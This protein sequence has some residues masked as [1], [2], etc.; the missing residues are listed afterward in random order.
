M[1][2][3]L[4]ATF[5][6]RRLH[7][8]RV[9]QDRKYFLSVLRN[10][11]QKVFGIV[12]FFVPNPYHPQEHFEG[13]SDAQQS[14]AE[15][16][17]EQRQHAIECMRRKQEA[18]RGEEPAQT[19]PPPPP[20]PPPQPQP[21][22]PPP[23][24]GTPRCLDD[25]PAGVAQ[26]RALHPGE[27]ADAPP[28]PPPPPPPP[29]VDPPPEPPLV[30]CEDQYRDVLL[31]LK[32]MSTELAECDEDDYFEEGEGGGGG[33]GGGA[34]PFVSCDNDMQE[35][36]AAIREHLVAQLGAPLFT[37]AFAALEAGDDSA[38]ASLLDAH[39]ALLPLFSQL[40]YCTSCI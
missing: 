5:L 19:P 6:P 27:R 12:Q 25:L 8:F 36:A 26:R 13:P 7:F 40:L 29:A 15:E 14:A 11:T 37:N 33:G 34:Q 4:K 18:M 28:P 32:V 21:P 23:P 20:P 22:P 38:A 9:R 16:L 30:S 17:W 1:R 3:Y 35:K 24:Q 31:R 39:K 10:G 2:V